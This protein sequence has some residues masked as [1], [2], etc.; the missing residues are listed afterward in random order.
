MIDVKLADVA[1][2]LVLSLR[3]KLRD[4]CETPSSETELRATTLVCLIL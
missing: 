1:V 4:Q 3:A 2:D